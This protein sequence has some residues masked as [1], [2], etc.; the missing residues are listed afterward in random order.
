MDH[1]SGALETNF[2]FFPHAREKLI[3][4]KLEKLG[5]GQFLA[6]ISSQKQNFKIRLD[7]ATSLLLNDTPYAQFPIILRALE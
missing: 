4:E 1:K 7:S 5:F 2:K 6:H 3:I